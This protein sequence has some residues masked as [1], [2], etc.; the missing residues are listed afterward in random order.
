ML[1]LPRPCADV[2]IEA[3][4]VARSSRVDKHGGVSVSFE[5]SSMRRM[6]GTVEPHNNAALP[7]S[8]NGVKAIVY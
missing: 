8:G 3:R 6:P 7:D 4:D 2:Q 1:K 5:C